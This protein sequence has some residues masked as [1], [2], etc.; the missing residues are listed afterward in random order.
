MRQIIYLI[1]AI[2][3]LSCTNQEKKLPDNFDFGKTENGSYKNE[4]FDMEISFDPNWIVQDKQQMNNIIEMGSELTTGEDK[5]LKAIVKASQ[6]NTAYLLAVFKHEVGSA[7]EFNPSFMVVAENINNFPGIKNGSDYLFHAKKLLEQSQMSY[8]FEKEVY[9]KTIG[10]ST[11]Y[12]MEAKLDHMNKT[13]IQH[14][15]S[16]VTKGFSLSFIVSFATDNGKNELY[17]IIEKIKI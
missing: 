2:T 7:V 1:I 11:F 3:T 8:Y 9:E 6:V 4:Y 12:I 16:T 17:E 5:N 13:V 14:Y 10:K 15:I